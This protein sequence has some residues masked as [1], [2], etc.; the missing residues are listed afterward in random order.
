[1]RLSIFEKAVLEATRKIPFG[2]VTTYGEIS[3]IIGRRRASRAV[4]NAL[5]KNPYSPIVPCHR[6]VKSNG[7]IGGFNK[8]IKA[9]V[10]MLASE[11]IKV[12]DGRIF[13]F[14]KLFYHF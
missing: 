14:Q 6:V 4:G 10:K 13:D 5:N 11:G 2:R 3:R 9:K 7:K 12:R 8:G 1:M